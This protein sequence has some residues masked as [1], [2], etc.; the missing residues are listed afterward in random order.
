MLI[1]QEGFAESVGCGHGSGGC[2]QG[3][4]ALFR[5][6]A[7]M[8]CHTLKGH[9]LYNTAV[10]AGVDGQVFSLRHVAGVDHHGHVDSVKIAAVDKFHLTAVIMDRSLLSEALPVTQLDQLLRRNGHEADGAA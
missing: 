10:A 6:T 5:G 8:G 3:V 9:I 7:G 4:D 1:V 2:I